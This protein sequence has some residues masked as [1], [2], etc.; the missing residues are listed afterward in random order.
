MICI[1]PTSRNKSHTG[2]TRASRRQIIA[3]VKG[4][5]LQCVC[6]AEFPVHFRVIQDNFNGK[7]QLNLATQPIQILLSMPPPVTGIQ[8]RCKAE[9]HNAD[10][11]SAENP[12]KARL[13]ARK[14]VSKMGNTKVLLCL[15][16]T[17][18]KYLSK[19]QKRGSHGAVEAA[20]LCL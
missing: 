10:T 3:D 17:A 19:E 12:V 7:P 6:L 8:I 15:E 14:S 11:T 16:K 20:I 1:L 2:T 4:Q 18:G 13:K 5:F 9:F